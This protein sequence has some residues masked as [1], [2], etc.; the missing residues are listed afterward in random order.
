[1]SLNNYCFL[2][3]RFICGS[4]LDA[5]QGTRLSHVMH[6]QASEQRKQK[7]EEKAQWNFQEKDSSNWQYQESDHQI[8]SPQKIPLQQAHFT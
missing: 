3:I 5:R 2:Y 1:M 4:T 6:Q 7:Q 8:W